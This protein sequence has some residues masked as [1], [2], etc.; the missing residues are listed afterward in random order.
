MYKQF[1]HCTGTLNV[2]RIGVPDEV[3][4]LKKQLSK[5]N[6]PRGEGM[7]VRNDIC[8][9]AVWKDTKCVAVMSSEYPGHS[10]TTVTRNV[11]Q[12]DGKNVKTDVSIPSIVYNYN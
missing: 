9:Y 7:Y 3:C 12:K 8:A 10:E 1:I 5:K 2:S 11:K 4:D 6:V